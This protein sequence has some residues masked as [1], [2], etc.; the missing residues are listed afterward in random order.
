MATFTCNR[1]ENTIVV[2]LSI[3]LGLAT[4]LSIYLITK[5]LKKKQM[6]KKHGIYIF[7]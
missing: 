6:K 5:R 3:V 2:F 1:Y 4:F 7:T